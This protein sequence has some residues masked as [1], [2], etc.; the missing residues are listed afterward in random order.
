MKNISL[1]FSLKS[2]SRL[3]KRYHLTIFIVFVTAGLGFA[4]F[5]FASLLAE[6]STDP[7]YNSPMTQGAIDE[8][9]LKRIESLHTSDSGSST[10]V[11]PTGRINPFSE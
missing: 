10:F 8:T 11:T 6:S 7:A 1:P 2:F 9:T 4:V 3:F 5:S